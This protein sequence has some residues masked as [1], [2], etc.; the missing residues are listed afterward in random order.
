MRIC[1][2]AAA[3]LGVVSAVAD[4]LTLDQA[5]QRAKQYNGTVAAAERSYLSARSSVAQANAAF[6]PTVSPQYRFLDSEQTF[7]GGFTT[8]GRLT[9]H[10][11]SV[12][13]NWLVLDGGQRNNSLR[14]SRRL[15]QAS[16]NSTLW[17]RRQVLFTVVRQFYDALRSQELL[18][19]ADAQ[20]D[21][22]RQTLEVTKT[23]VEVGEAAEKDTLQAEAD[24]ANAIV[25]QIIARNQVTTS[26]ASLK[27][28][29]GW[30]GDESLPSLEVPPAPERLVVA[31]TLGEA[32]ERGLENRPDLKDSRKRLEADRFNVLTAQRNAGIDWQ[33]NVNY[34][35]NFE[36][37]TT[38]NRNITFLMTYPLFDAG[39][40]RET[41]R[42]VRLGYES[43]ELLLAQQVR[44]VR[45]E[46]ES[47]FLTWEQNQERLAASEVALRAAQLNYQAAT[48]SQQAGV[49][50]ILD[51]TNA[52][53]SLV[54]AETNYVQAVYDF[55]IADTQ[56]RLVIGEPLPGEEE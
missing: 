40:T 33:L 20:V 56:L 24:L 51:V 31:R 53:V 21:R 26:E 39:R 52:Q 23:Q 30:P 36:P 35:R 10:Q 29:I 46:I 7:A 1:F 50:S 14:R 27:A 49:S 15:A 6:F 8:V 2:L 54:T 3:L 34:S 47:V 48:E 12:G 42:Q 32:V 5:I 28:T 13:A 55:Y 43:S 11:V 37:D 25:Q 44:D 4:G 41:V 17:T 16:K 38:Q 45:S 9:F 18:K 19:V 22:A